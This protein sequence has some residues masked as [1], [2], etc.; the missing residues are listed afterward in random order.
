MSSASFSFGSRAPPTPRF[1]FGRRRVAVPIHRNRYGNRK[2]ENDAGGGREECFSAFCLFFFFLDHP[3]YR[4]RC[5]IRCTDRTGYDR[6]RRTTVSV[7][8]ERVCVCVVSINSCLLASCPRTINGSG[9]NYGRTPNKRE[10]AVTEFKSRSDDR[11]VTGKPAGKRLRVPFK[12][13]RRTNDFT[14][15][16]AVHALLRPYNV[17]FI[18]RRNSDRFTVCVG[19]RR[20]LSVSE[21]VPSVRNPATIAGRYE[22]FINFT[23]KIRTNVERKSNSPRVDNSHDHDGGGIPFG[24]QPFVRRSTRWRSKR[25]VP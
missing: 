16:P 6:A 25:L 15:R 2:T 1:D 22:P 14:R 12:T 9:V 11:D 4:N 18:S 21:M 20:I 13:E 5:R 19:S 17:F 24:P 8:N 10:F 7:T 23:R 3:T